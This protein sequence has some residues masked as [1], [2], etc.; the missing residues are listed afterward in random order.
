MT[1][2]HVITH[3]AAHYADKN[4]NQSLEDTTDKLYWRL[5]RMG[6]NWKN[7][8]ADTGYSSGDNYAY[9][10]QKGI[11]SYIP[12][13]GQYKGG[14][15]GFEY[16]EEGDYWECSQG[17]QAEFK[18]VIKEK[19]RTS[20]GKG[21]LLKKRYLTK[22]SNCKACPIKT[23]CIGKAREKK[24]EIT[25][26]K[27]EYDRAISRVNSGKGQYYKRKRSSTVEPV[28][29]ILTQFMGM[30]KIYTRG[31]DKAN[32]CMLMS[33]TAYNLKKLLKRKEKPIKTTNETMLQKTKK[34]L[35]KVIDQIGIILSQ[36]NPP[37]MTNSYR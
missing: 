5:H 9:L 22:G 19:S 35:Q 31:L 21:Y 6:L 30:A 32:K 23:A 34:Q 37:K 33:A 11:T 8:L 1:K 26:Y 20:Y 14:P 29:G 18:Q 15:E 3:I 24:I 27:K 12:P 4:D 10:E 13:H 2:E 16:N 36:I 17:I 7:L 25:Y 28:F